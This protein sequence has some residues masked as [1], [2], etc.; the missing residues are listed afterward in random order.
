MLPPLPDRRPGS[1]SVSPQRADVEQSTSDA[2]M[3]IVKAA[4]Q[5]DAP[6]GL[7]ELAERS[8]SAGGVPPRSH[9]VVFASPGSSLEPHPLRT[10]GVRATH[11]SATQK[12]T[13]LD[14][15]HALRDSPESET[16]DT[17]ILAGEFDERHF[18]QLPKSVR[19]L[20]LDIAGGA[21]P[22][23]LA[24]LEDL[25]L[26][27]LMAEPRTQVGDEGAIVLGR[28]PTLESVIMP[29]NRVGDEGAKGLSRSLTLR[30]A[31]LSEN[32]IGDKGGM[33]FVGALS[34]NCC[35]TRM[36]SGRRARRR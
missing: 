16:V 24:Q 19:H 28:H 18:G 5:P 14:E 21:E 3:P 12:I 35:F 4:E 8:R 33:A 17:L 36:S 27:S 13:S 31:D 6:P 11:A 20:T 15:L 23:A 26:R 30:S 29:A 25:E 32:C 10:D 9:D 22:A 7:R 1:D 34:R 2:A